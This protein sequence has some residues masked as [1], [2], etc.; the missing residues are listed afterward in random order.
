V[1][2][3][4]VERVVEITG[5]VQAALAALPT[6]VAPESGDP[7][8]VTVRGERVWGHCACGSHSSHPVT[9]RGTD[10]LIRWQDRHRSCTAIG[11]TP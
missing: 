3:Q 8:T 9:D 5:V 4:T 1:T 11:A 7:F 10:S 6:E 2:Q